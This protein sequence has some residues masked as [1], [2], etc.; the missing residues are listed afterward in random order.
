MN[1]THCSFSGKCS[2]CSY[3]GIPFT[4][5][6]R[7]KADFFRQNWEEWDLDP[8]PQINIIAP[9]DRGLRDRLDF[10]WRNGH[11]GLW[12][13][14]RVEILD[15]HECFQ[16]SPALHDWLEDF[17]KIRWPSKGASF[18][19]R[20]S[21]SGDRG[22]WLDMS[23]ADVKTLFDDQGLLQELQRMAV[24]EIGQRRKRLIT[25]EAG[26]LRLLK[27]PQFASWTRT[28]LDSTPVQ[29]MSRIADFS[30]PGDLINQILVAQVSRELEGCDI[31]IDWGCGSGNFTFPLAGKAK[32]VYAFDTDAMTL[33][34]LQESIRRFEHVKQ[35]D[36]VAAKVDFNDLSTSASAP[37]GKK[38]ILSEALQSATTWIVDPP[39]SGA[40]ALLDHVP[41]HVT[42]IV[43][44]SCFAE[45]FMRDAFRL[46]NHGFRCESLTMVDQFPQTPHAEWVSRWERRSISN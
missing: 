39:R 12:D 26:K 41:A 7:R 1:D 17:R 18:R 46:H 27:E 42:R 45:S 9:A 38:P 28:W 44:V 23:H 10:Q 22:V 31:A 29:L 36:I 40:G 30:Q 5:Q 13:R 6:L 3:W 32:K 15:L 4:T 37:L 8:L 25:D 2:G 34:G 35:G 19:L 24:V 20:V 11:F 14:N 21:P 16:L 33:L 43:A